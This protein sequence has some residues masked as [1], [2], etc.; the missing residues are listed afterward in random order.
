MSIENDYKLRFGLSRPFKQY[1][2]HLPRDGSNPQLFYY[3]A[4][5]VFPL[6]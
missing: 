2:G 1:P 3:R 4:L 6:A 5:A